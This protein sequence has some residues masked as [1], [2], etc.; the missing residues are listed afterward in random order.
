MSYKKLFWLHIKKSAGTSTRALLQPHYVEVDRLNKP[1]NFIQATPEE[2]NDILNTYKVV[3]GEYQFK[4]CLFAKKF[5]YPECWDELYSFAFSR[6]PVDRCVSMFYY[7]YWKDSG[8]FRNLLRSILNYV[9]TRKLLFN[10]SYAF[11]AFLDCAHEARLSESTYSPR[12]NLFTTH[13]A[14]VWDDITDAEGNIL[15]KRVFRLEDLHE[16][17]NR[18]FMEC[19]IDKRLERTSSELNKNKRRSSYE[20]NTSQV[21]RIKE[22]YGKDFEIYEK[23][24]LSS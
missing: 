17:I 22:I 1:K 13:T 5:L 18:A 9:N 10:T 2:Y 23:A 7:V 4:R 3:L 11:D 20:P 8:T 6:D 14:P 15:L 16:G 19:G 21:G 12:G 24:A